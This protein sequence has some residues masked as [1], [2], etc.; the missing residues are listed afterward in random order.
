MSSYI[1]PFLFLTLFIFVSGKKINAFDCFVEGAKKSLQI[2]V[3]IFPFFAAIFTAVQIFSVSGGAELLSRAVSP[4]FSL[5]GIPEELARLVILR[6]F[7][8]SGSLAL[9]T[10]I[11]TKYGADSYISRCASILM[12]STETVFY[13]IAVYF[14][15]TQVKKLRY[16]LPVGL[17]CCLS[18]AII[19]CLVCR[20]MYQ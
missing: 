4:A 5:L 9:V 2:C 11:Y 12:G 7:S 8:G 10:E 13:L 3:N 16:A 14:T 17:L 15:D 1:L 6:P 20:I 19:S 18:G